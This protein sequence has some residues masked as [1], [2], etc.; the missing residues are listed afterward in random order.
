MLISNFLQLQKN[1]E[2][3]RKHKSNLYLLKCEGIWADVI[4]TL[5]KAH[6]NPI[7]DSMSVI[8]GLHVMED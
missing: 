1:A 7:S 2:K 5:P 3:H 4:H 6:R 8:I